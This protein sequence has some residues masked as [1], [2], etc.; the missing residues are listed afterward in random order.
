MPHGTQTGTAT[1]KTAPNVPV[2]LMFPFILPL[3][4]IL[5]AITEMVIPSKVLIETKIIVECNW[6]PNIPSWYKPDINDK[7]S[8]GLVLFRRVNINLK[9]FDRMLNEKN[10]NATIIVIKKYF[11]FDSIFLTELRA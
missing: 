2:L 1:P 8:G 10:M 3:E 6:F 11:L 4:C 7:Y 9:F 5:K